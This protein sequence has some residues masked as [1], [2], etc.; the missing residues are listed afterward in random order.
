MI[1]GNLDVKLDNKH[2]LLKPGDI[3]HIPIL[4]KHSFSTKEGAVFEEISTTHFTDDSFY[5][6]EKINSNTDR[7]S[8]IPFS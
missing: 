2:H 7:K 6:D 4:S 1:Y 5:T 8:F 3:L